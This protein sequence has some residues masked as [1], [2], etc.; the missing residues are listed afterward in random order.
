MSGSDRSL[1]MTVAKYAAS[2]YYRQALG[3]VTTVLRPR[4]LSPEHFGLWTLLK[5]VLQYASYAHLGTQPAM[6]CLLPLYRSRGDAEHSDSLRHVAFTSGLTVNLTLAAVSVALALVPAFRPELR[7]G[8]GAIAILVLLHYHHDHLISVLK[9]EQDFDLITLST[10][11]YVTTA[12]ICTIPLLYFLNIYGLYLS[13][14]ITY[15]V[16]I[17][18]LHAAHPFGLALGMKARLLGELV[19]K[20]FPMM[21]TSFAV[22]LVTTCD[23]IVV[24][25]MLGK[26]A[27]GYYGVAVIVFNFMVN[28]PGTARAVMEPRLMATLETS[29]P[30]SVVRD[31][32][33]RPLLQAAYLMP[34][35]IGPVVF[36]L[37]VAIPIL[38]P[39]YTAGIGA[40]QLLAFGVHFLAMSYVPRMLIIARNWQLQACWWL[41]PVVAVNL[42]LSIALINAGYG[43]PGVAFASSL[44]FVILFGALLLFLR[45]KLGDEILDWPS[46]VCR[47]AL[48]FPVMYATMFALAKTVGHVTQNR[49][50]AAALSMIL[51]TGVMAVLY[52]AAG[53]DREGE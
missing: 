10:Y 19:G 7:A 18:Q 23:R 5:L 17:I 43:L 28:I 51:Y 49:Y 31:Y 22:I 21:I 40:A 24:S 41:T 15:A 13:L 37:P 25:A 1:R 27:L 47:L 53:R 44:S 48:P 14:I 4:L 34:F 12:F 2:K 16:T 38:L 42:V 50:F 35:L 36:A 9:A 29:A 45:V 6:R 52:R 11:V 32:L 3:M 39:R 30:R 20:G 33:S 8:F 26:A 46:F